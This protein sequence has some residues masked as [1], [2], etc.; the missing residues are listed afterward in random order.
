VAWFAGAASTL[1]AH[2]RAI[3]RAITADDVEPLTWA[4]SEAGHAVTAALYLSAVAAME[5]F[6]RELAGWW[7]G[8][9]DLLS[10][11]PWPSPPY[12]WHVRL[13][14]R[15]PA[16][17]LPRA[18]VHALHTAFN[19][20]GQPA[21]LAAVAGERRRAADRRAAR[22]RLRREDVLVRLASQLEAAQ[23]VGVAAP[24]RPRGALT[25]PGGRSG[26]PAVRASTATPRAASPASSPKTST[27]SAWR[28]WP[29]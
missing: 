18:G 4:M 25:W 22:R 7:D 10:P 24:A 16:R 20:T 17:R 9:F 15:R 27:T 5:R 8:G 1:D 23:P 26:S 28:R 13:D 3:G 14:T 29:S 11:L 2:G 12:R 6:G 21:V 19:A